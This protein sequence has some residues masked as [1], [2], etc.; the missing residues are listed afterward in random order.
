M[1]V[2]SQDSQECLKNSP[3]NWQ[4]EKCDFCKR[5]FYKQ[6]TYTDQSWHL[7][8]LN[9]TCWKLS[10]AMICSTCDSFSRN[11]NLAVCFTELLLMLFSCISVWFVVRLNDFWHIFCSRVTYLAY[12][13]MG[14]EAV[15]THIFDNCTFVKGIVWLFDILCYSF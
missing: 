2:L 5:Y 10:P 1:V 15:S 11:I 14:S 9:I 13:Q 7:L 3:K 6:I 4:A 8:H 12:A